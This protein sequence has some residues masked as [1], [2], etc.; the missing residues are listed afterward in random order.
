MQREFFLGTMF[1][2]VMTSP[3]DPAVV[4]ERW[5]EM[6]LARLEAAPPSSANGL[7]ISAS[8][9]IGRQAP[10]PSITV[11]SSA[12]STPSVA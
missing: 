5:R 1:Q 4:G 6:W 3:P 7:L 12:P 8:T 2:T 11:A 9:S 10:S